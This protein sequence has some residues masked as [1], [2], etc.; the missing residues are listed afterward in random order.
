MKK[1]CTIGYESSSIMGFIASLKAAGVKKLI[2]VRAVPV[3]RKYGFSKNALATHLAEDGIDYIQLRA[4][5]D[6]KPGREAARAGRY[7]EFRQVY[8]DHLSGWDAQ[9]ALKTATRVAIEGRSCLLCYERD[10]THC[11]RA[12]VADEIKRLSDLAVEHLYVDGVCG[13]ERRTYR[14]SS[15]SSE[16]HS[17]A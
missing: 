7:S 17:A 13:C 8:S 6:P 10:P 3:S 1:I 2:D 12:I 14:R 4:L 15:D 11:H 16:G 5:G 9:Q